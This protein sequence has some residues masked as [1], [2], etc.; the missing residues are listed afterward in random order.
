MRTHDRLCP[1]LLGPRRRHHPSDFRQ[2]LPTS[3]PEFWPCSHFSL[4]QQSSQS[5]PVNT[6]NGS[7]MLLVLEMSNTLTASLL[8]QSNGQTH[9]K[10]RQDPA[11]SPRCL[12]PHLILAHSGRSLNTPAP[13]PLH[14]PFLRLKRCSP[15]I[16]HL[17]Q[18]FAESHLLRESFLTKESN[19]QAPFPLPLTP[20]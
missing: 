10:G 11:L 3:S 17:F 16:W 9:Y 2:K 12:L 19:L 20:L 7:K 18:V 4:L 6:K 8:P 1:S 5:G 14:F 15:E 13:G